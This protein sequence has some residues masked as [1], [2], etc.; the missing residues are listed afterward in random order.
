MKERKR[1]AP[2]QGYAHRTAAVKR[3]STSFDD[4]TFGQVRK[5][6]LEQG[7]SCS[8]QVRQLVEFGL[9]T[10]AEHNRGAGA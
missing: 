6:A 5:L 10:L 1:R 9:E 7:T 8:E 4:E 3:L 2:A